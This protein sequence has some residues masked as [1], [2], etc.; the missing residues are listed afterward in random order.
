MPAAAMPKPAWRTPERR[1][2]WPVKNEPKAPLA[3]SPKAAN[4]PLRPTAR[5]P[6]VNK[7]FLL[8]GNL[9]C[10]HLTRALHRQ[11]FAQRHGNGANEHT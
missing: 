3:K 2:G 1:T 7:L 5:D 11:P 4:A 6:P 9:T 8:D 10:I